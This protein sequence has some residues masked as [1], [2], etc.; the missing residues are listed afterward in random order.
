MLIKIEKKVV[1]IENNRIINW[2][3]NE[4]FKGTNIITFISWSASV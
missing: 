2:I 1:H 3:E 4:S